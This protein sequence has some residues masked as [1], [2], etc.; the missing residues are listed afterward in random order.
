M[1]PKSHANRKTPAT[2]NVQKHAQPLD[3]AAGPPINYAEVQA[4][5]VEVLQAIYMEDYEEVETYAS[6]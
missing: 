4:E 6:S 2:P 3:Q 1:A 5:E